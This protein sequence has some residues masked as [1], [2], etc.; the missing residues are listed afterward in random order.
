MT[1]AAPARI[2]I[3]YVEG[4]R[5]T[6]EAATWAG[7]PY[8]LIGRRSTKG[9]GG[10]CSGST[11]L[12]YQRAGFPFE[13]QTAADFPAYALSSGLFRELG[14]GEP[15]Q[16]GD[17]LSWPGHLAISCSFDA[18]PANATTPRTTNGRAWLQHND[19]WTASHPGGVAYG[20]GVSA[21]W[22]RGHPPR[23]FRYLK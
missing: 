9:V 15:R 2:D 7:T 10:D 13:Y 12:V 18:D 5:I 21:W 22:V 20:P 1:V 23:V 14:P 3:N 6:A 4:R 8:A 16:D 11:W 19:M 17:I